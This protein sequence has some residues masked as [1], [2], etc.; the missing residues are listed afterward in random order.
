MIR[1]GL[2]G[3]F[4]GLA[5]ARPGT[6]EAPVQS[7]RPAPRPAT[8]VEAPSSVLVD[9]LAV[10]PEPRPARPSESF[11]GPIT[12]LLD[13]L[14]PSAAM[15]APAVA[16]PPAVSALAVARSVKPPPRPADLVIPAALPLP[17]TAGGSVCGVA[18]IRGTRI[19]DIDGPGACGVTDAVRVSSVSGIPLSMKPTIDCTTARAL[20]DWVSTGILPAVGHSGGG[21][22]EITIVAHYAC[23]SRN[24]QSG[25]KLSEHGKGHAVD[26]A[27]I[28]LRDGTRLSVLEHWR[29]NRFG[30]IIK[31]MHSSACG[32]FGTVLGPNADRFHQDHIHV[33]T[34]R[35]RGGNYCH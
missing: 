18:A 35:Y 4:L 17:A 8:A 33:D 23:R 5:L 15:A 13:S 29:S 30:K 21:L 20:N 2:L 3:L 19:A 22:A 16:P 34:A 1:A 27:G 12:A 28:V 11:T 10:R 31:A 6:A 24:N 9:A 25:A 7:L 14:G 32:P 26:V